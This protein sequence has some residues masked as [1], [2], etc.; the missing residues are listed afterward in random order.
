[1]IINGKTIT[2]GLIIDSPW[3]DFILDGL[4]FWEMRTTKTKIRGEIALIK[5]GTGQI[6]GITE[7]VDALDAMPLELLI[8]E[9]DKHKVDYIEH[10]ELQKWNTPWVLKNT[11]RIEPVP[12]THKR[13]AVIWV[14]L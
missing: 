11:R 9:F 8:E 1:M 12:Y 3:I 13:G 6:V 5:K 14:N 2:K 10:P 7:L 4:K